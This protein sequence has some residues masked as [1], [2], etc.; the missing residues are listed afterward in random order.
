MFQWLADAGGTIDAVE[1][2]KLLEVMKGKM[3]ES[4]NPLDDWVKRNKRWGG[5]PFF[6]RMVDW[7]HFGKIA[8]MAIVL[9]CVTLMLSN[10]F[11]EMEQYVYEG[12]TGDSAYFVLKVCEYLDDIGH[13]YVGPR[14]AGQP[15]PLAEGLRVPR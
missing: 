1:F 8:D 9:N 12:R 14:L 6:R 13:N 15:S 3:T 11:N 7:K 10:T 2:S 5:L 4:K